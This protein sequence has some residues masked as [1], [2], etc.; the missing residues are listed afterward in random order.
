MSDTSLNHDL[1]LIGDMKIF[2]DKYLNL[3]DYSTCSG[4]R[5]PEYK[6]DQISIVP[7]S[8]IPKFIEFEDVEKRSRLALF[9]Q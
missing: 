3:M 6:I 2:I 8:D 1:T 9:D 4:S 5:R 7:I